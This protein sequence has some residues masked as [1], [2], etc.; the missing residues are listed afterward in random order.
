[1]CALS[2]ISPMGRC[3]TFDQSGDGYCRGEGLGTIF[4]KGGED[5]SETINQLACLLGN[6]INQDGRSASMT[7][8]N[9]PSQTAVIQA[10]MRESGVR[11]S[12]I[13]IA[14]CHGTGTALGDPI[15]VGA[16]R[17]AMEP[18]PNNVSMCSSKCFFGHL[19]G[20]AGMAGMLKCMM[21]LAC[22]TGTTNCHLR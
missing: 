20:G 18:R 16:L 1:M 9:G 6:S 4:L 8:P 11:A 5:P 7:A 17:N 19:E 22:G 13:D 12:D 14:E 15:E 2:M 10:S 21:M 3:F